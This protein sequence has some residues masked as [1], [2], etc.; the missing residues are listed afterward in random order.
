MGYLQGFELFVFERLTFRD[1]SETRAVGDHIM[2]RK[3]H[4]DLS[5]DELGIEINEVEGFTVRVSL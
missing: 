5:P 4:V 1:I 2:G 3:A